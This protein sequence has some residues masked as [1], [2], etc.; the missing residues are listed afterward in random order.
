VS[1]TDQA[2][3]A[4]IDASGGA[5][6]TIQASAG[7]RWTVRQVSP[8]GPATA[9]GLGVMRKNGGYISRFAAAGDVISGEPPVIVQGSD[10]LT[11][12]WPVLLDHVGEVV[13]AMVIYDDGVTPR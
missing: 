1:A 10:R 11:L 6:I 7:Q 9:T 13:E 2:Y 8:L 3:S 5:R 12:D 4:T